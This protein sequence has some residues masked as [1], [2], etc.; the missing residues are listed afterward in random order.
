[1][2][3]LEIAK[4]HLAVKEDISPASTAE[5]FMLIAVVDYIQ[6]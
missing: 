2:F 3:D 4:H 5:K 1:L 6:P